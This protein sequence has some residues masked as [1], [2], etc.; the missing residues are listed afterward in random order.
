MNLNSAFTRSVVFY[1]LLLNCVVA[2]KRR[3]PN[4]IEA[5]C[6]I[7]ETADEC[8]ADSLSDWEYDSDCQ[9]YI[10][11]CRYTDYDSLV[12][13]LAVSGCIGLFSI[14]FFIHSC[15]KFRRMNKDEA[16]LARQ[17]RYLNNQV[18]IQEESGF[19]KNLWLY[20]RNRIRVC[21]I[22]CPDPAFWMKP[23]DSLFLFLL[24]YSYSSCVIAFV[25]LREETQLEVSA[26]NDAIYRQDYT[27]S[28]IQAIIFGSVTIP[29]VIMTYIYQYFAYHK[30]V[31]RAKERKNF[32]CIYKIPT[33]IIVGLYTI[34]ILTSFILC[35]YVVSALYA[36]KCFWQFVIIYGIVLPDLV[37]EPLLGVGEFCFKYY[38][39]EYL[40][41]QNEDS[42]GGCCSAIFKCFACFCRWSPPHEKVQSK[43]TKINLQPIQVNED[44]MDVE[45]GGTSSS[46]V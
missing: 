41:V 31:E 13:Y 14:A 18:I 28:E 39:Y 2:C 15:L 1:I 38:G 5:Q 4:A 45:I 12:V 20:V 33:M 22:F 17:E 24:N 23:N 34:V 29:L 26:S 9:W 32:E 3:P 30:I 44:D 43:N 16:F 19:C 40:R 36:R 6:T 42:E 37:T 27:D 46:P 10:D 21:A 35:C 11:T 8:N 7:R 25:E